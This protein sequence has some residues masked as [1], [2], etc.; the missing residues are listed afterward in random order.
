MTFLDQLLYLLERHYD[1]FRPIAV[2][3]TILDSNANMKESIGNYE[4]S[5]LPR[6]LFD[7]SGLPN[8]DGEGKSDLVHAFYNSADM[9]HASIYDGI[10]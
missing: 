4:C 5:S 6:S 1:W 10:N 8:H 9:M 7:T 3:N 2:S